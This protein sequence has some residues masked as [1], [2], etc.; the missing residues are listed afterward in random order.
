MSSLQFCKNICCE[1]WH[2]LRANRLS[3]CIQA[4][5]NSIKQL[6]HLKL[7]MIFNICLKINIVVSII[8]FEI[9]IKF[10]VLKIKCKI[11]IYNQ[12][13]YKRRSLNLKP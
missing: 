8:K 11:C 1:W 5:V 13:G 10:K 2:L 9:Q 6:T 7:T 12:K 4:N 3:L